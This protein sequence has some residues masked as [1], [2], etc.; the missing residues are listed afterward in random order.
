MKMKV[1]QS[2]PTLCH[3]MDCSLPGSSIH[4][5]LQIRIL[6][7]V[8]IPFSRGS[9]QPRDWA[10]ISC[11]TGRFLTIRATRKD[12]ACHTWFAWAVRAQCGWCP[13]RRR[14]GRDTDIQRWKQR[15]RYRSCRPR[16]ARYCWQTVS[17]QEVTRKD[18]SLQVSEGE[19]TSWHFDF[20]RL[21]SLT[22][23]P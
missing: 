11:I 10:C 14:R 5:I 4:G 9:S 2:C 22:V 19:W 1:T 18:S 6:E 23:K 21:A 17:C 13:S 8:A 12:Q 16:N 7:W 3:P 20:R 15:L